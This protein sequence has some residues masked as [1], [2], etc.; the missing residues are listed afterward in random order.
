MSRSTSTFRSR[1]ALHVT[2]AALALAPL[3]PLGAQNRNRDQDRDQDRDQQRDKSF[4]WSGTIPSG[5]RI[6]IKNIN[7]GIDVERSASNRVEVTA[8]K[9]WRRGDPAYVR[10]E[11]KKL[12]DEM[13]ICARSGAKT[14]GAKKTEFAANATTARAAVITTCPSTLSCGCRKGCA[15]TCPP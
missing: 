2:L 14:R 7:G 8:E 10:I 3:G 4:S 1:V 11:P 13:L 12:G 6:L 9:R 15:L 5:K